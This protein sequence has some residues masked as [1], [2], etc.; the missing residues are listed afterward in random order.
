MFL[1]KKA[2]PEAPINSE[3]SPKHTRL[4]DRER[5]GSGSVA[6]MMALPKCVHRSQLQHTRT[7]IHTHTHTRTH[8][9]THTHTHIHSPTH[10]HTHT[11]THYKPQAPPTSEDSRPS[12]HAEGGCILNLAAH[13]RFSSSL[14]VYYS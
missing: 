3:I 5:K 1:K 12:Y 9:H 10:T 4:T 6:T 8:T 13:I 2:T 7:H 11:H 14:S